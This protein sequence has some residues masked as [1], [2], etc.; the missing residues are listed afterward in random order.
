MGR[1]ILFIQ[2]RPGYKMKPFF[3]FKLRTMTNERDQKNKLLM[4]NKRISKF[5]NF[6]RKTSID[7][8][9]SLLNN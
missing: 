6:L 1:P 7:E 8:L 9:P 2:K 5:G 3:I 4:D